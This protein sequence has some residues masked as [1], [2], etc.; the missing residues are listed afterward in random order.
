M[1]N[2]EYNK[3][4]RNGWTHGPEQQ[5][6]K[7]LKRLINSDDVASTKR[8]K[9]RTRKDKPYTILSSAGGKVMGRY[10]S[11]RAADNALKSLRNHPW[12][13]HK[14]A[15]IEGIAWNK[16]ITQEAWEKGQE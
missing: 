1:K 15:C 11:L 3:I 10:P 4:R 14:C 13:S 16:P 9:R 8:R 12:K 2:N 6:R 7:K 5:V